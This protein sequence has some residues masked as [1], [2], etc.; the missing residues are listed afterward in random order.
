PGHLVIGILP[1]ERS[2]PSSALDVAIRTGMGQARNN[3][4]VVSSDVL[5]ACGTGGP[6]TVSEIALALKAGKPIILLAA[7]PLSDS[8]FTALGRDLVVSVTNAEEA[9]TMIRKTAAT[10]ER[11][12]PQNG[13]GGVIIRA[14]ET[15]D[16]EEWLRLR[17]ALWPDSSREDHLAEMDEIRVP[18][19]RQFAFVAARESG[20][21]GGF[22]EVSIRPYADGCN[23]KPVGYLEGW[24]VDPDL[25]R[26]GVGAALVRAAEA[27]AGASGCVEMG[28][29]CLLDNE[30]GLSS[31]LAIGYEE[32]ERAIHL[33]RW[34]G[35]SSEG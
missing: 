20:G 33:R 2:R 10:P 7:D 29:D 14:A 34:I 18:A 21:L 17:S 19:S 9:I 1:D 28:S 16:D 27:W 32:V 8:Y 11:I 24:Y 31:H 5:V 12:E 26:K 25:R 30:T 22:V 3:I 6:G 4:N 23:T 15:D 13:P 35:P